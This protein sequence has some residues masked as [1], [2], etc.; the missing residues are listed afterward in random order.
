VSAQQRSCDAQR[1]GLTANG[2]YGAKRQRDWACCERALSLGCVARDR[3]GGH[4]AGEGSPE[5]RRR[6]TQRRTSAGH[7]HG[8]QAWRQGASPRWP[9]AQRRSRRWLGRLT[10]DRSPRRMPRDLAALATARACVGL[11]TRA[12]YME[13]R[14]EREGEEEGSPRGREDGGADS[15]PAS[16]SAAGRG[17]SWRGQGEET[18]RRCG[19]DR[20]WKRRARLLHGKFAQAVWGRHT[21]VAWLSGVWAQLN[22]RLRARN[23]PCAAVRSWARMQAAAAAFMP[24]SDCAQGRSMRGWACSLG[25]GRGWAALRARAGGSAALGCRGS[26]GGPRE[27]GWRALLVGLHAVGRGGGEERGERGRLGRPSWAREGG[28]AEICFFLFFSFSFLFSI[29]FQFDIMHKQMIK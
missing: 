11:A 15:E 7:S 14:L 22:R 10:D 18:G 26:W 9:S 12:C 5:Q 29:Y 20:F 25:Y 13:E 8:C 16:A 28:W 3:V 27:L 1:R 2:F 21:V 4:D 19:I 23:R 17:E 24:A 6:G